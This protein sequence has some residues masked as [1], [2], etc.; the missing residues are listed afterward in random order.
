MD[1][2]INHIQENIVDPSFQADLMPVL[3]ATC[4]SSG[5]CH[6]SGNGNGPQLGLDM[7]TDSAAYAN[8]VNVVSQRRGPMLRV[9]PGF[10][11]SS[12]MYRVLFSDTA[13]RLGYPYRMPLTE[14]ALPGPTV[15]AIANWINK[16]A[17][18]N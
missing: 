17:K 16:G 9:K 18:F 5:A 6:G 14:Y 1:P 11:D 4:A 12:F 10:A 13:T 8:L 2:A 15:Q 7:S 3:R